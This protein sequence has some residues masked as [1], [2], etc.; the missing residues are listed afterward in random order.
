MG[1]DKTVKGCAH[2][3]TV[4]FELYALDQN[5]VENQIAQLPQQLIIS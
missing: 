5:G 1:Y 2:Q 3:A 4:V